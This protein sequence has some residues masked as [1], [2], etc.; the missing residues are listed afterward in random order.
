MVDLSVLTAK[1]RDLAERINK[2]RAHRPATAAAL[3]ADQD[4][5][6]LVSF[7]LMLAVQL[8]LDVASHFI[9]DEG[10]PPTVT[11][12]EAFRRLSEHGVISSSTAELLGRAVGLRNVVAHGYS[13]VDPEQIFRAAGQGLGDL[14]TFSR[15]VSTWA[16]GRLRES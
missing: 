4:R 14:E 1:L 12:A 6:D 2:V 13:A 9:G 10:W 8:C 11:A 16:A 15:E 5:L 7:N 3:A